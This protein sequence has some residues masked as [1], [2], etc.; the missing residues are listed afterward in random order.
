MPVHRSIYCDENNMIIVTL[1][2][3]WQNTSYCVLESS[4]NTCDVCMC[5]WKVSNVPWITKVAWID[6]PTLV[7]ISSSF[8]HLPKVL[9]CVSDTLLA[10]QM[11]L[12]QSWS[13]GCYKMS[14]Q[15][16]LTDS[17]LKNWCKI[18]SSEHRVV[19][20]DKQWTWLLSSNCQICIAKELELNLHFGT[21]FLG[22]C[23]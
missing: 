6:W 17:V 8:C 15:V 21:F 7:E 13:Y 4:W 9:M 18:A 2:L 3:Y 19:R 20:Q 16:K 1:T 12:F 23:M 10:Q 22:V 5:Y 14:A 11:W